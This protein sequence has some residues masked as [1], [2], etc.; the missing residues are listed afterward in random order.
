MAVGIVATMAQHERERISARTKAAPAA[1]KERGVKLAKPENLSSRRSGSARGVAAKVA[2]A[3]ARAAYIAPV[4]AEMKAAGTVSLHAIARGLNAR[5]IPAVRG[6]EW[7]AV[8]VRRVM[9]RAA[10]A[11]LRS[12]KRR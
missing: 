3:D 5:G 4:L 10:S 6:G 11:T 2:E 1:A 8:Q 12:R 9:A 7:S